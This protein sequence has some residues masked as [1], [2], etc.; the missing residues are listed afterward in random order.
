MACE[1]PKDENK[2]LQAL[3]ECGVLDTNSEAEFDRITRLAA[4]VCRTP[5]AR[6]SLIDSDREW[7]KSVLGSTLK[8]NSRDQ[9]FCAHTI[10]GSE[11][12]VVENAAL[13]ARFAGFPIVQGEH[14]VRFYAGVPIR[15]DDNHAL[16]AVCVL[17][18]T[19]RTLTRE[20]IDVLE[21]LAQHAGAL[22]NARRKTLLLAQAMRASERLISNV[23]HEICTPLTA[24]DGFASLLMQPELTSEQRAAYSASIRSAASSLLARMSSVLDMVCMDHG[25]LSLDER[26]VDLCEV[27]TAAASEYRQRAAEKGM[28]LDVDLSPQSCHVLTDPIRIRQVLDHLLSNAVNATVTGGVCVSLLPT[29]RADGRADVDLVVSDT[30]PGI[31]ETQRARVFEPFAKVHESL[32]RCGEGMGL[33][34]TITRMIVERMG[35]TITLESSPGVGTHA[36]VRLTLPMANEATQGLG[37]IRNAK[38]LVVEDAKL[39]Q[40]LIAHVLRR[41]GAEVSICEDGLEALRVAQDTDLMSTY[42]LVLMDIQMP[43]M[44]GIQATAAIRA[45]GWKTPII[46]LTAESSEVDRQACLSAGCNDLM[47]KPFDHAHLVET[48]ARYLM[49]AAA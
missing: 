43:K 15:S 5:I 48:C 40:K 26:P 46:A 10:M 16:G 41:A 18:H 32:R 24:I 3:H 21:T 33:G 23:G 8:E 28:R 38:I 4:E 49:P 19:P 12:L 29:M 7:Y 34:L 30:G 35:G 1:K 22:L 44:D 39:I 17:D 31:P 9:A 27:A 2:R 42:N 6:I 11:P 45:L 36:R 25:V 14:G 47:T 37:S 13:D 20:Q